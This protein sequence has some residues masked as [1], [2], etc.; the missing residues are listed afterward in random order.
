MRP[1]LTAFGVGTVYFEN[2]LGGKV[3]SLGTVFGGNNWLHK[4]RRH[5]LHSVLKAMFGTKMPFDVT[6]AVFV[7]PIWYRGETEDVLALY[8]FSIDDQT[9]RLEHQGELTE[10]TIPNMSIQILQFPH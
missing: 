8:N 1:Q 6:D 5:Q 2:E 4:C 9:F 10:V 3:L 7:A